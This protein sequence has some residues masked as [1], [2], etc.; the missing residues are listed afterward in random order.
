[1]FAPR[2]PTAEA[3]RTGIERG[4]ETLGLALE[5]EAITR[6]VA[7]V[8]LLDRWN[9]A[10]NLTAVRDPQAML[11]HHLLDCLAIVKPLERHLAGRQSNILDVGSG[12]G[13]PGVVLAIFEP[14]WS[15]TCVDAVGKKAAF[16]QQVAGA[17]SLPNLQAVHGRVEQLGAA[18]AGGARSRFDLVTAR[19]FAS[20]AELVRLTEPL[21][22]RGGC[23][24]AMKGADRIEERRALPAPVEVFHVEPLQVPGLDAQRC[25]V[26]MRRKDEA[27]AI[28]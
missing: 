21:L 1:M 20:L 12:G 8:G 17:L 19:A 13:L 25:L 15:V 10:Y 6:F 3:L 26:W 24:A 28:G 4:A 11:T 18:G 16:V 5:P 7:F 9:R 14:G 22:A 23:W 27:A 2:E